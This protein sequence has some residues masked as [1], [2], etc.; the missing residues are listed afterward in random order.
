MTR[1]LAGG[2][3]QA[4]NDYKVQSRLWD[5]MVAR[6][7]CRQSDKLVGTVRTNQ[8]RA[9]CW[10]LAAQLQEQARVAWA[11]LRSG[12][13]LGKYLWQ[14]CRFSSDSAFCYISGRS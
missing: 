8:R 12:L 2:V 11:M 1:L 14:S 5:S 13:L 9:G 7:R 6:L 4:A 10:R 3:E